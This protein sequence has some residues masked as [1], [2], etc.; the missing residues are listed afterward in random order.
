MYINA[1][2]RNF[3]IYIFSGITVTLNRI[4]NMLTA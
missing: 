1:Y 2:T 4:F 3:I